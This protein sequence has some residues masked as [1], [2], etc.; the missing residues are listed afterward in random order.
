MQVI[1]A[2]HDLFMVAAAVAA[3]FVI[4]EVV[5]ERPSRSSAARWRY[6]VVIVAVA[7]VS[8]PVTSVTYAA[9]R[10][11]TAPP[12]PSWSLPGLL[13]NTAIT[14]LA[15]GAGLALLVHG[16]RARK[17]FTSRLGPLGVASAGWCLVSWL[18]YQQIDYL[19][20]RAG[21]QQLALGYAFHLT[22]ILASAV[23]AAIFLRVTTGAARR[24]PPLAAAPTVAAP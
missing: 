3:L 7:V 18:P 1:Y 13:L 19:I 22:L 5:S 21:P 24:D 10:L 12:P 17:S 16:A 4:R 6:A 11:P 15:F 8:L 2:I 23:L 14:R 9:L 20:P